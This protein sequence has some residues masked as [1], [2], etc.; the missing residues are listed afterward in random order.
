MKSVLALI[1]SPAYRSRWRSAG[2]AGER[3]PTVPEAFDR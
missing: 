3:A 2:Q 1:G